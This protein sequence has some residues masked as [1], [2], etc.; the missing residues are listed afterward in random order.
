MSDEPINGPAIREYC[1]KY[2]ALIPVHIWD[3]SNKLVITRLAKL[4]EDIKAQKIDQFIREGRIPHRVLTEDELRG[5][6]V[7]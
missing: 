6:D 1:E 3:A 2:A 4:P 5:L 7:G